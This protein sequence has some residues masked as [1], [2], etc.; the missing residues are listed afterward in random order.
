MKKSK[1][2]KLIRES[3]KGLMTEQN[4]PPA[5]TMSNIQDAIT[6]LQNG[7]YMY[8]GPSGIGV[9]H[10]SYHC[11]VAEAEAAGSITPNHP[12]VGNAGVFGHYN[13][14]ISDVSQLTSPASLGYGIFYSLEDLANN[15]NSGF[16]DDPSSATAACYA[17]NQSQQGCRFPNACNYDPNALSGGASL[18]TWGPAGPNY[19]PLEN[20]HPCPPTPAVIG[21]CMDPLASNYDSTANTDDGSCMYPA[22]SG[23]TAT[24][25][26]GPQTATPDRTKNDPDVTQD[27]PQVKRMKKLANISK[28]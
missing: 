5:Y 12:Q 27:N 9:I 16:Y 21:G 2:R 20:P 8:T 4:N 7:N 23:T 14:S 6:A 19:G 11:C 10:F 22:G 15:P 18:C 25:D 13:P 17:F 26:R 3:I 28:K 24:I 1:L